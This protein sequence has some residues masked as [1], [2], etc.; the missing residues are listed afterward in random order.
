VDDHAFQSLMVRLDYPMFI[1]TTVAGGERDGC[2]IAF[3]TQTSIHPPRFLACISDKN[4]T[5]RVARNADTLVVHLV[6]RDRRDLAELFGGTTGDEVDKFELCE[7]HEGPGHVPVLDGCPSWFAGRILDR[8]PLGDHAGHL[9]EPFG[10]NDAG[11]PP[12]GFSQAK[13]IHPGHPA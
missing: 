6:P 13:G 2:L 1:V 5:Y 3:A 8:M 10:G 12:F 4:R 9:V 11:D 7:W